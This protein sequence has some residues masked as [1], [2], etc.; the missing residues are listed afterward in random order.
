MLNM[1]IGY[2]MHIK[3]QQFHG[4]AYVISLMRKS[5]VKKDKKTVIRVKNFKERRRNSFILQKLLTTFSRHFFCLSF[6]V[7]AL[8]FLLYVLT[9]GK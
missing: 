4:N 7:L 1:L 2:V 3:F 6:I 5:N 9:T 8:T